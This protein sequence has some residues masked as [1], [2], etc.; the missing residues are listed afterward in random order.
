M[1]YYI[2]TGLERAK[3]H[4]KVRDELKKLGHEI[5]YDWSIHGNVKNIS[6]NK[7]KEVSFSEINAIKEADF[8]VILL[9]G[10]R[11]THTE[12]GASLAYNKLIFLHT[13]EE[14]LLNLGNNTCAFYHHK[15][16]IS[17]KCPLD[18]FIKYIN[19]YLL[20]YA[21]LKTKVN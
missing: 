8:I 20:N 18:E 17:F 21:L 11:G 19:Q 5:T 1:K 6:I 12:L 14:K 2:A 13:S 10:G 15:Q 3:T 7:L 16:I 9:P 4:N